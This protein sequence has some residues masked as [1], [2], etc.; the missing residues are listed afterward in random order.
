M[1]P[2]VIQQPSDVAGEGAST[3][4]WLGGFVTLAGTSVV[5]DDHPIV[6]GEILAKVVKH[7]VIGALSGNEQE[8][9]TYADL[10]IVQCHVAQRCVRHVPTSLWS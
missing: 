7:V 5:V 10:L 3:V 6:G 1:D 8:R 9:L 2:Q 4:R